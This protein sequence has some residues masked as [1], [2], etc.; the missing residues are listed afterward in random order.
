LGGSNRQQIESGVTMGLGY[1]LT[2]EVR[3]SGGEILDRNF[4]T[5]EIP[6]LS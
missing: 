4:D 2:E 3:S 5:C 1:P 6:R